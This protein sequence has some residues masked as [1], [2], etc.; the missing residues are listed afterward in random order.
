M[1]IPPTEWQPSAVTA[2]SQMFGAQIATLS[3]GS[4]PDPIIARAAASISVGELGE[5]EPDVAV[6]ETFDVSILLGGRD[7]RRRES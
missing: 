4:T 6:D 1:T 2:H 7:G 5:R 3:P